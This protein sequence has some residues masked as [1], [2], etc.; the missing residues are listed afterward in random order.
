M[1]ED[2]LSMN[3]PCRTDKR[4]L[5]RENTRKSE[6]NEKMKE[7]KKSSLGVAKTLHQAR[8]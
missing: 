2:T 3:P 4:T 7:I 5:C 8:D 6:G 1:T